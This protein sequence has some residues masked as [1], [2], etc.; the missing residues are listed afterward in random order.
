MKDTVK[1]KISLYCLTVDIFGGFDNVVHS[2]AL[3]SL[4]S[5]GVNPSV[6]CLLSSWYSKS[7]IQ[8]TWN[9]QISDPVKINN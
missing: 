6:L 4:A 8:V 5:P 9:D 2:Q 1:M 3:S 7:E